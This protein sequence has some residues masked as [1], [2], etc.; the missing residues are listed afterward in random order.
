MFTVYLSLSP[1]RPFF[2][3]FTR[4]FCVNVA[5]AVDVI[6]LIGAAVGYRFHFRDDIAR[7]ELAVRR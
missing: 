2:T 7:V 5:V 6:F 1:L 4:S 3:R